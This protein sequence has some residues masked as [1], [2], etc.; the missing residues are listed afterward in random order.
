MVVGDFW[1]RCIVALGDPIRWHGKSG[2]QVGRLTQKCFFHI[3]M[4]F[5]GRISSVSVGRNTFEV[6]VLLTEI[7]L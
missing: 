1:W 4:A 3:C 7:I 6:D 5:F 2:S